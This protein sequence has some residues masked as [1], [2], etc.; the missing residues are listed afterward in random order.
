MLAWMALVSYPIVLGNES[1]T[2]EVDLGDVDAT[3]EVHY[4]YDQI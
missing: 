1:I 3:D 4:G 2:S